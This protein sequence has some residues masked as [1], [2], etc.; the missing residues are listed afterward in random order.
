MQSEPFLGDTLSTQFFDE[1]CWLCK[2]ILIFISTR[3][4]IAHIGAN[5]YDGASVL[6]SKEVLDWENYR[7]YNAARR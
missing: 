5:W 6:A 4:H 1:I 7:D 2:Y 3:E